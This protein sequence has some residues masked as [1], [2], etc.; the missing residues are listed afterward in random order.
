MNSYEL[1]KYNYE[2]WYGIIKK[3]FKESPTMRKMV[4]SIPQFKDLEEP[5]NQLVPTELIE[6]LEECD[7]V[8]V[9]KR[10]VNY[11]E[12]YKMHGQFIS[13]Q[14]MIK[15]WS[16]ADW[17]DIEH[18]TVHR[19]KVQDFLI[20]A[21]DM[22]HLSQKHIDA[23]ISLLKYAKH[24]AHL[25]RNCMY[26]ETLIYIIDQLM[27]LTGNVDYHAVVS[28]KDIHISCLEAIFKDWAPEELWD[29]SKE[30]KIVLIKRAPESIDFNTII[31]Y[32]HLDGDRNFLDNLDKLLQSYAPLD[33]LTMDY[34][35]FVVKDLQTVETDLT[36]TE[37]KT[38][39]DRVCKLNMI[40]HMHPLS[41][42]RF[43]LQ[44]AKTYDIKNILEILTEDTLSHLDNPYFQNSLDK[45]F[46][47]LIKSGDKNKAFIE[48]SD[49]VFP[50]DAPRKNLY[51]KLTTD[52]IE[53]ICSIDGD[54]EE[55]SKVA[56]AVYYLGDKYWEFHDKVYKKFKCFDWY[57]L[58]QFMSIYP[59]Q[60]VKALE[61]DTILFE[62]MYRDGLIEYL[63]RSIVGYVVDIRYIKLTTIIPPYATQ[64]HIDSLFAFYKKCKDH[65][66]YDFYK[67]LINLI[68]WYELINA[69]EIYS[70]LN[71]EPE[72]I[73][74]VFK[75][76]RDT[77]RTPIL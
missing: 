22:R 3:V 59:L 61:N 21:I 43:F 4:P 11:I 17:V 74:T 38:L 57:T 76:I 67:E 10:I 5:F 25:L 23:V 2:D 24:S 53:R 62:C 56:N 28:S 52:Q 39:Y 60:T 44:L 26:D 31:K 16:R 36:D 42:T 77:F 34:E 47:L 73:S 8:N 41:L 49:G 35:D 70:G 55:I 75:A 18:S 58:N 64:S 30:M 45:F 46:T 13:R 6:S 27:A 29:I 14:K 15:Y 50:E 32:K 68:G 51:T 19:E 33:D 66:N 1:L 48:L 40:E 54:Y 20:E 65:L 7:T 71:L 37:L 72:E 63:C 9:C 12:N 69:I